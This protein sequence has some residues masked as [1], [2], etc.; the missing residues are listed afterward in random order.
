MALE[1]NNFC[2]SALN[3]FGLIV[4]NLGR[5]TCLTVIGSFFN[6]LGKNSFF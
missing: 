2:T 1:G 5:W 3:G 4:R 6:F